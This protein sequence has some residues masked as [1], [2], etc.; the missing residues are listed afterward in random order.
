MTTTEWADE[1]CGGVFSAGQDRLNAPGEAGIPHLIAPGCIVMCNFGAPDTI[2]VR[3]KNRHFYEWNPNVT[4][5][6]TT[7]DENRQMGE[8]F[9]DRANAAKGKVGFII[10][11]RGV[12]MLDYCNENGEPQLFWDPAANKA[13]LDGL[14]NK[15]NPGIE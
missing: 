10:P 3:Y 14:K 13:F 7:A 12:S 5:M 8:L 6:R 1:L 9:A 2:H 15:L 4:P 11:M